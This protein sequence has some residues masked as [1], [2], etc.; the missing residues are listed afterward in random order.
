MYIK[1]YRQIY[2]YISR[3][4]IHRY[5]EIELTPKLKGEYNVWLACLIDGLI[6]LQ[7]IYIFDIR[8]A[9][10]YMDRIINDIRL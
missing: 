8:C 10:I 4:I 9:P 7:I 2:R 3:L 6:D 5:V 1:I